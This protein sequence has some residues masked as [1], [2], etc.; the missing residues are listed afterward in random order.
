MMNGYGTTHVQSVPVRAR[1]VFWYSSWTLTVC[2]SLGVVSGDGENPAGLIDTR[3]IVGLG[4]RCAYGIGVS[5][6]RCCSSEHLDAEVAMCVFILFL[7]TRC[8]RSTPRPW[9]AFSSCSFSVGTLPELGWTKMDVDSAAASWRS[10]QAAWTT[11]LTTPAPTLS[12]SHALTLSRSH[13]LT[14][15]LSHSHTLTLSHSHT[16]TPSHPHTLI[17]SH[18]HTLT[19]SHSHTL[20][21]TLTL[22]HFHTHTVTHTHTHC[23]T[24]SHTP[25]LTHTQCTAPITWHWSTRTHAARTQASGSLFPDPFWDCEMS[26]ARRQGLPALPTR[27]QIVRVLLPEQGSCFLFRP[28]PVLRAAFFALFLCWS[29]P[30]LLEHT[31]SP[32][33]VWLAR[34]TH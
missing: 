20:T 1:N 19:P 28:L 4:H 30:V 6:L 15:T 21:H 18:P 26:P 5:S 11:A 31:H 23:H 2:I 25:T 9:S 14:L 7:W 33:K 12:R 8:Y 27:L 3:L 34:L 29:V 17:P 22:S 16:L 13:T 32:S 10:G 24:L